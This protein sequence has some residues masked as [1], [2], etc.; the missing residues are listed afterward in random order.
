MCL[1]KFGWRQ[2]S[3]PSDLVKFQLVLLIIF[4]L[5]ELLL[6]F[7]LALLFFASFSKW[8]HRVVG[9]I[10]PLVHML[11]RAGGW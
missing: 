6:R 11:E 4:C 5:P 2:S 1:L 9:I 7:H 10:F 8:Q 3:S